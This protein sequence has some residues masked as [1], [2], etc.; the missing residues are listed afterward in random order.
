MET[1]MESAFLGKTAAR[2]IENP[3]KLAMLRGS[4][5]RC[6][7]CGETPLFRSYL[8]QVA[9]CSHCKAE[10]ARIRSDDAAPWL[11]AIVI[12]HIFLPLIF[13][14]DLESYMPYW[15]E[16]GVWFVFFCVLALA[17]LPRAKGFFIGMLW[18]TRAPG[19]E[20]G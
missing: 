10:F 3:L 8:K 18:Q 1:R 11:T 19:V 2:Y 4:L 13:L 9:A 12:G 7:A 14:I 20:A 16:L 5:G 17:L 6:P 15:A